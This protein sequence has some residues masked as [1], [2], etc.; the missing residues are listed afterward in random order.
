MTHQ[1]TNRILEGNRVIADWMGESIDSWPY[2]FYYHNS[3]AELM[4]VVEKIESIHDEY[5]GYFG[6][7]IVSNSCTIQGTKL[8]TRPES[9]HPAYFADHY[10]D[11]KLLATYEAVVSFIQWYTT[12]QSADE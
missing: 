11:T 3:W 9:F 7:H 12:K 6:V 5:H 4:P 10:H 1:E 8:D 2:E